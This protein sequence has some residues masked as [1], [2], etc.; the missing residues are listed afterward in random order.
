MET[1][2]A[3]DSSSKECIGGIK[4]VLIRS[5]SASFAL[6]SLVRTMAKCFSLGR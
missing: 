1:I 3:V 6:L 2:N 5:C 4:A